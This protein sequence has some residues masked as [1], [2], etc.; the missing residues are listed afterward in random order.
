MKAVVRELKVTIDDYIDTKSSL[1]TLDGYLRQIDDVFSKPDQHVTLT[2][3]AVRT[4]RMGFKVDAAATGPVNDLTVAELSIGD[5]RGAI[6]IVRCTRS[7]LP[8]KEN[9][10]AKAEHYL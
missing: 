8:P 6:A 3:T 9:L 1:N 7:E 10:V 4:S 2:R 5:L